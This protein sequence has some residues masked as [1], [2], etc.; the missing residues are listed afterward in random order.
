[1]SNQIAPDTI[2]LSRPESLHAAPV[3]S[4]IMLAYNHGPWIV[5]AIEGVLAQRCP[6]PIELI[7]ADDCSQ[8]ATLA[9]AKL[10]LESH[11]EIVRIITG[12][13]NVGVMPNFFRALHRCRGEYIAFCEG[14]DYWCDPEKL[15][16]QIVLFRSDCAIGVVHT[17]F[18]DCKHSD[19]AWRVGSV[20]VHSKNR[21][22]DLSGDMFAHV[23]ERL[24]IRTCTAVYRKRVLQDFCK[25]P[26]ANPAFR[27]GDLSLAAFCTANWRVG[28]IPKVTA[29]YRLSPD[30]ATR[31][32]RRSTILFLES[33]REIYAVL[34]GMYGD[35]EDFPVG[36]GTWVSLAL[37]RLYFRESDAV[38]FNLTLA[39]LKR[40]SPV[41]VV[42]LGLVARSAVI[43]VPGLAKLVNRTVDFW[44]ALN[45]TLASGTR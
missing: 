8:D 13:K 7:V 41:R 37:A 23:M 19:G 2:E 34:H 40:V 31:S 21:L 5:E 28:Y 39:N 44:A 22:E 3:V 35:R 43:S 45:G 36:A 9:N 20:G 18:I 32:G 30:S 29:T 6:F 25:T 15:A 1:M 10:Y 4:V 26:L 11:P 14:D 16:D 17:D 24:S 38:K 27:A 12:A 42:D 33:V